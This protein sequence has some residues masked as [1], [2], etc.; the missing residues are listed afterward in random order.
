MPQPQEPS[1]LTSSKGVDRTRELSHPGCCGVAQLTSRGTP[2]GRA[3]CAAPCALCPAVG[4]RGCY[5]LRALGDC[6]RDSEPLMV[7]VAAQHANGH[8]KFPPLS[9]PVLPSQMQ[10]Q[11][12]HAPHP[13]VAGRSREGTGLR[14]E[15][16]GALP[17]Q[18]RGLFCQPTGHMSPLRLW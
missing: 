12:P 17:S 13:T 5:S 15:V 8:R 1:G 11:G 18:A 9:S 4:F 10:G 7:V 14:G 16:R 2:D 6:R 3:G